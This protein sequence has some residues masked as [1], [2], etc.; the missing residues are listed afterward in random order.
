MTKLAAHLEVNGPPLRGICLVVK[1]EQSSLDRHQPPPA[2][3]RA[4]AKFPRRPSPGVF[5]ES[6]PLFFIGRNK[7]GLWVVRE[8][9]GQTG[10]IFLFRESAMRFAEDRSLPA[11][12]ATMFLTERFELDVE[13]QGNLLVA[14]LDAAL[15]RAARLLPDHPP[16]IP[17]RREFLEENVHDPSETSRASLLVAT[18][19]VHGWSGPSRK[20]GG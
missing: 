7:T 15:R 11:G 14:W 18:T 3:A 4:V 1:G 9:Q 13:N 12:C 16:S 19:A 17:I 5:S 8:A 2:A 6:I 10:G 20:L